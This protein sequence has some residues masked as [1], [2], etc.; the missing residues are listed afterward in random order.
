MTCGLT[1]WER[2]GLGCGLS[3]LAGLAVGSVWAIITLALLVPARLLT[4]TLGVIA[5]TFAW[6][7]LVGTIF[8][9]RKDGAR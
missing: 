9:K 2:V 6:C 3:C 1:F 7:W 5:A 8:G 4:S